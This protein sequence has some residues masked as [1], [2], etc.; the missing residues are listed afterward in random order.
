MTASLPLG[1]YTP[2]RYPG[3]KGKLAGFIKNLL[4]E[5]GLVDGEYA[6]PYA[7]GAAIAIELLLQ[8]FVQ[9]I[10]INDISRPI[11]AFWHSVLRRTEE[12]CRLIVDTPV[13]L[14]TWK[15][16]RSIMLANSRTSLLELGFATFFLNRTNRS[17]IL[18]AGVIGGKMQRGEWGID[19][20]YNKDTLVKRVIAIANMN[21]RISLT[22]LDAI[23]FLKTVKLPRK[24]LIYLDP[25]YYDKG[26]RLYYDSYKHDDHLAV[27]E[28]VRERLATKNWIVSYDNV[29]PIRAMYS[30]RPRITYGLRY[31][32]R[33]HRDG[34]EV[35]FF[36]DMVRI[37]DL[38]GPFRKI[39]RRNF[40][41]SQKSGIRSHP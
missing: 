7:G 26:G 22:R 19:A 24:T 33:D 10:H 32:A 15:R 14:N 4:S 11:Y 38:V 8:E 5:N 40:D 6:E 1:H 30:G 31:S 35:I 36:S 13:T 12:L 28:F 3:G 16:Q 27:A 9:R 39:S 25:P 2:L 18:N 20:R 41:A 37:V 29:A 34:T 23:E 21:S 17:G